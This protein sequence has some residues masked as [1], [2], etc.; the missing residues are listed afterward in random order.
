M[1]RKFRLPSPA[2]AIARADK[3]ALNARSYYLL[4]G[5]AKSLRA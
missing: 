2:A 1:V 3:T 4:T 5:L